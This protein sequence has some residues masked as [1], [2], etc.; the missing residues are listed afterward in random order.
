[1]LTD[2]YVKSWNVLR[3]VNTGYPPLFRLFGLLA[4]VSAEGCLW[5][6]LVEDAQLVT[7]EDQVRRPSRYSM[8]SSANAMREAGSLIPI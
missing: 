8:I 7:A 2:L 4:T 1:M 5:S 6:P 3:T